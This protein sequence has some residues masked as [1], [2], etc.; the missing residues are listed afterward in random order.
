M[1]TV[2]LSITAS[3]VSPSYL[4]STSFLK[5]L[6]V[7]LTYKSQTLKFYQNLA[8]QATIHNVFIQPHAEITVHKGVIPD[9]M[10]LESQSI[11]ATALY[12]KLCHNGT[13]SPLYT[14]VLNLLATTTD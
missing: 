6:S 9:G 11:T 8:A 4:E 13:I 12:I 1:T 10:L 5:Y 14:D 3:T 2:K 7:S